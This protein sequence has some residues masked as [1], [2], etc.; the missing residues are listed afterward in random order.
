MQNL[1]FN[2]GKKSRFNIVGNSAIV[3]LFLISFALLIAAFVASMSGLTDETGRYSKL[4]SFS[5]IVS[6]IFLLF[7]II[8]ALSQI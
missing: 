2:H 6:I 3:P 5:L 7:L 4:S 8:G 1:S